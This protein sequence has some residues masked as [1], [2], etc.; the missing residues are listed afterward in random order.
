MLSPQNSPPASPEYHHEDDDDDDDEDDGP[1]SAKRF[2]VESY[3]SDVS[4]A[5]TSASS[6]SRDQYCKTFCSHH[7]SWLDFDA[8]VE[9][10]INL[11][12]QII[13][14]KSVKMQTQL[15]HQDLASI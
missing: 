11:F 4:D 15:K 14:C 7:K 3:N 6:S 1:T 8:I 12:I 10:H 13:P 2:K 9:V 5:G